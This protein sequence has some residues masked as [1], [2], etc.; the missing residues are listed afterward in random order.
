[1]TRPIGVII[2]DFKEKREDYELVRKELIEK[3]VETGLSE[4]AIN[5]NHQVA[6][7]FLK[8]YLR[9]KQ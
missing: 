7:A 3:A 4:K 9:G 8:G 1:M 2:F 5:N 6:L